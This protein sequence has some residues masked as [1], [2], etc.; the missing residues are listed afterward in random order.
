MTGGA[1]G[2]LDWPCKPLR[3]IKG[4]CP[5]GPLKLTQ[6]GA[7]GADTTPGPLKITKKKRAAFFQLKAVSLWISRGSLFRM[8]VVST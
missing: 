7:A 5:T 4:C 8:A 2:R 3:S 1:T 6:T